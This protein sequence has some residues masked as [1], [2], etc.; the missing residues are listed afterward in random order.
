MATASRS[1]RVSGSPAMK[2]E[3]HGLDTGLGMV[4][5]PGLFVPPPSCALL[6][7]PQH[8]AA[9]DVT[10]PQV[11]LSPAATYRNRNIGIT[12]GVGLFASSP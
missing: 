4:E 12:T 3:L 11:K 8:H 5:S 1:F 10:I 9:P 6:F 7:S 2:S